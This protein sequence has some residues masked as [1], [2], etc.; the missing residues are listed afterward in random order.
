M[1]ARPLFSADRPEVRIDPTIPG[2]N[3]D[4]EALHELF[5]LLAY[6]PAAATSGACIM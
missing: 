4:G 5:T 6:A 1:V 3:P 2:F